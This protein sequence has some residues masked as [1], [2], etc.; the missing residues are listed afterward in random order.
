MSKGSDP[1]MAGC[2]NP[3]QRIKKLQDRQQNLCDEIQQRRDQIEIMGYE[4]ILLWK[5]AFK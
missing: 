5:E 3:K 2:T 4:I 1:T